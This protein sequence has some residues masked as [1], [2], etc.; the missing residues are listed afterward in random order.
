[1]NGETEDETRQERN[2]QQE[3][4]QGQPKSPPDGRQSAWKFLYQTDPK[5][6]EPS[7]GRMKDRRKREKERREKEEKK[8]GGKGRR[9]EG[10]REE[11]VHQESSVIR[12][13]ER[14]RERGRKTTAGRSY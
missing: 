14:G 4:G 9:K 11:S 2:T 10:K 7:Y 12:K 5:L 8:G 1:M 3:Q 13:K 6:S